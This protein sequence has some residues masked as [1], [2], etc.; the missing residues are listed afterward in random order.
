VERHEVTGAD[1]GPINLVG[2]DPDHTKGGGD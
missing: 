1:G 2:I